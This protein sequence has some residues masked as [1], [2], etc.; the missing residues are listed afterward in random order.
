MGQHN[1]HTPAAAIRVVV[2]PEC[3]DTGGARAI[4]ND[5]IAARGAPVEVDAS[6]VS[7]TG[8]QALQV[9]VSAARTWEADG[10]EF[11]IVRPSDEFISSISLL[12]LN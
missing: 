7:R 10:C 3:C 2:L 9:I 1:L 5:F 11:K 4:L 12:G 8:A 6:A